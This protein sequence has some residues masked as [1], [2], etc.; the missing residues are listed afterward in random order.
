MS[1]QLVL[2]LEELVAAAGENAAETG[3][4]GIPGSGRSAAQDAPVATRCRHHL[5]LQ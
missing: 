1:D 4:A 2:Q 3:T 5:I